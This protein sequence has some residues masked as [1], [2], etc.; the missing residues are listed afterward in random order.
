MSKL[1]ASTL[2]TEHAINLRA[3]DVLRGLLA[4][5][6]LAGH[7]RWLLW[8]G[9]ANWQGG[10]HPGWANALAKAGASLRYGHE[11]V[12]VFFVLSGFFI[13]LRAAEQLGEGNTVRFSAGDFFR[14]RV[15]R[16]LPPY[17]LALLVTFTADFAGRQIYPALYAGQVGDALLD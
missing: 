3:L 15:R 8:T 6:V 5:Y 16:L 2:R 10:A 1:P 4:V 9:Y 11:A 14:R 7:A 17:A 12:M 13:H